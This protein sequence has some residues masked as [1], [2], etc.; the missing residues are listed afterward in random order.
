MI[1]DLLF[2]MTRCGWR[3]FGLLLFYLLYL[4]LGAAVFSAIEAP[5]GKFFE[6]DLE[7]VADL[8]GRSP[9]KMTIL[10]KGNGEIHFKVG[11]S[12]H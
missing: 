3:V 2:R 6:L 1:I 9:Q 12:S 10:K 11:D 7:G 5:I 4:L 8:K